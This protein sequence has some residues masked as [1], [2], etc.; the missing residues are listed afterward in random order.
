MKHGCYFALLERMICGI[1][2]QSAMCEVWAN[3]IYN[4]WFPMI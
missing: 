4:V 3:I 1:S 2:L